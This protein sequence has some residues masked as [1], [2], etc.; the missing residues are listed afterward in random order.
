[1]TREQSENAVLQALSIGLAAD[2]AE[3]PG[4]T[5][6]QSLGRMYEGIEAIGAQLA[7]NGTNARQLLCLAH[8]II[9]AVAAA[10]MMNQGANADVSQL[11]ARTVP[12][13]MEN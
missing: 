9:A 3:N 13:G 12:G 5:V 8:V 4:L 2:R 10:R 1:M 7:T 6:H 11:M